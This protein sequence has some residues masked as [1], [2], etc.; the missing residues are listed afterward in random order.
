M[1]NCHSDALAGLP[2]G[3]DL[4][5]DLPVWACNVKLPFRS[6]GRSMGGRSATWSAY[7][8]FHKR[9]LKLPFLAT[10]CLYWGVDLPVDL[11]ICASTRD[12][13]NYHSWPLDA[14]TGGLD[15]PVDPPIWASTIEIWKCHSWPLDASTGGGGD[16]PKM[17]SRTFRCA[18]HRSL[19]A[20]RKTNNN[21]KDRLV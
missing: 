6:I 15:L 2:W 9:N 11:P 14:S 8:S 7:M 4:P 1:W 5:V 19:F 21:D 13:W 16:L 18:H 17:S 12:I 3:V 20:S 10:R